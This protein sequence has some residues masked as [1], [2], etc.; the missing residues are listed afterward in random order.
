MTTEQRQDPANV[1]LEVMRAQFSMT[2]READAMRERIASVRAIIA[3]DAYAMTFQA[4][5]QYRSA[6][7]KVLA[8]E[9]NVIRP[10]EYRPIQWVDAGNWGN[11]T[12]EVP[13]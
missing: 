13:A 12:P 2:L 1:E 9:A 5:G 11:D 3:D 6:L 4:M 8:S 7:L 10:P